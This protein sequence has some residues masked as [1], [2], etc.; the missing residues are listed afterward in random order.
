MDAFV[1]GVDVGTGSVR[2]G[3]YDAAGK[4]AGYGV[5]DIDMHV[6]QAGWA[7]QS[8]KDIWSATCR[9]ISDAL[10]QSG[11]KSTDI[12]G[13]GFDATCSLVLTGQGGAALPIEPGGDN[14]VILWLDHR[15]QSCAN[16]I[17]TTGHQMLRS[18]GGVMSPEMQLPKLRWL[19]E[20]RHG[21]WSKL[22]HAFDLTDWL[23]WNA[24]GDDRRSLCTTVCKWAF[25]TSA[26]GNGDFGHWP[27]GFFAQ[28][29][30]SDLLDDNARTIGSKIVT[31]GSALGSG[32]TAQAAIELGLEIGTPVASGLIDA[33]AGAAG[34]WM[35]L[36]DG[37]PLVGR[38]ALIAG[39]SNCHMVLSDDAL[40]T[41]G[42]WGPYIGAILPGLSLAE[43]GQSA[44]GAFLER[45]LSGHPA[46]AE[47]PSGWADKYAMLD[48]LAE[49]M[50][51]EK[52]LAAVL[53]QR[54]IVPDFAGN[55]SPLAR[56]DLTGI[57]AG[58][59]LD[60]SLEDLTA[61]Y[62]AGLMALANS[63][64]QIVTALRQSGHEITS[65]SATG[66]GAQNRLSMQFHADAL[67]LPVVTSARTDG[68]VL[69]AAMT[70]AVAAAWFDTLETA[71]LAMTHAGA[72]ITPDI[73]AIDLHARQFKAFTMLQNAGV[74]L[75]DL[76]DQ[77]SDH[78]M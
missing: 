59:T 53:G 21:T 41:P 11:L 3:I 65:I 26:A 52:G 50:I 17:N 68:V 43:G 73:A 38:M 15:S 56:P 66:S 30:L 2:A 20:N 72:V 4:Q 44:A 27:K 31:P 13:I 76:L 1:I 28:I 69:G 71:M 24:T 5:C 57:V 40:E 8:S 18:V 60:T 6:P 42:V 55:R 36:Q 12:C 32:L 67:Q 29:G 45:L 54:V 63:T 46:F 39:T 48:Q 19:K 77:K 25:D 9:S 51:D 34:I 47:L 23:T 64:R 16:D 37:S 78:I 74:G 49:R 75:A 61:T 70:A 62:L 58:V 10:R 22:E 14:D 7:E 33:H 35:S